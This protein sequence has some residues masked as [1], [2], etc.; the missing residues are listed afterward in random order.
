MSSLAGRALGLSGRLPE[1]PRMLQEVTLLLVD[2]TQ[3]S[4]V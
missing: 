3:V 1:N 2:G 4:G